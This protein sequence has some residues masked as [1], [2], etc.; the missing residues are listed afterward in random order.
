[1]TQRTVVGS[2][3]GGLLPH[4]RL[5]DFERARRVRTVNVDEGTAAILRRWRVLLGEERLAFG[6]AYSDETWLVAE[7]DGSLVQPD[8]L[9]ARWERL[10]RLAGVRSIGLHGARHTHATLALAA[11]SPT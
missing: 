11:G 6:P 10:E 9:S 8:T 5:P 1:M 7:A 2:A 4:P 3:S